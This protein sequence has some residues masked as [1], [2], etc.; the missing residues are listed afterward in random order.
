M[1]I[2]KIFTRLGVS[3]ILATVPV[4]FHPY[5]GQFLLIFRFPHMVVYLPSTIAL[6]SS[7]HFCEMY[8]SCEIV[9]SLRD[10]SANHSCVI[11][12]R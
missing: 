7:Y 6:I 9:S 1:T 12:R 5:G 11:A 2:L 8:T 3:D 10:D 4:K